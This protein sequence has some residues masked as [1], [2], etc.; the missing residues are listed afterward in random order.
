MAFSSVPAELQAQLPSHRVPTVLLARLAVDKKFQGQGFGHVLLVEA[1]LRA[2][3]VQDSAGV[4][5]FEVDALDEEA[6]EF[7]GHY[8]FVPSVSDPM[9]LFLPMATVHSTIQGQ[10]TTN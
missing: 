7:Y 8:G 4:I 2:L 3:S 9:K 6:L 5:L 1:F 10:K